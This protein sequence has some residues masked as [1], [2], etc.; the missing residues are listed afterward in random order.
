MTDKFEN[1]S[2]DDDT[3]ILFS[4]PANFGEYSVLYQKW[5]FDGITGESL[6]FVNDDI[7][8]ITMAELENDLK[9]SPLVNDN[10]KEIT[11]NSKND[12]TFFNFNFVMD[13]D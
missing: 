6:I 13:D 3:K 5:K 11:T 12:Y 2:I 1:V 10:S 8:N 9:N 7:M 4:Q